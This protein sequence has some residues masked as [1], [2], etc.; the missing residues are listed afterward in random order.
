MLRKLGVFIFVLIPAAFVAW[1]ST[2]LQ[3][4]RD[5]V[6]EPIYIRWSINNDKIERTE[7]FAVHNSGKD[8]IELRVSYGDIP[9]MTISDFAAST[10]SGGPYNSFSG[11]PLLSQLDGGR[12]AGAGT[13]EHSTAFPAW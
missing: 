3:P 12:L 7:T 2:E 13:M 6:F 4:I 11:G 9:E 5:W 1:F 8:A 10:F